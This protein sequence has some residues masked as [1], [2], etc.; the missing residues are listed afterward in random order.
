MRCGLGRVSAM[1]LY[2][3]FL[4]APCARFHARSP[5]SVL[6]DWS[7]L[8]MLWNRLECLDELPCSARDLSCIIGKVF[9]RRTS[10]S[11]VLLASGLRAVQFRFLQCAPKLFRHQCLPVLACESI[12]ACRLCACGVRGDLQHCHCLPGLYMEASICWTCPYGS[13]TL[14]PGAVAA[15]S[16]SCM[17]GFVNMS[18][19]PSLCGPC[20][21]GYFCNGGTHRERCAESQTTLLDVASDRTQCLCVSGTF[22]FGEACA[23]CPP[24]HYKR[25]IGNMPC[26]PCPAGTWSNATGA[27]SDA[28]CQACPSGST[29][30]AA[31]SELE[32][33]CVRPHDDQQVTCTSGTSCATRIPIRS[34]KFLILAFGQ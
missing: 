18:N 24:G 14:E 25:S 32:D 23:N 33:F 20:G 10:Y 8:V 1:R 28:T 6:P 31:G 9:L 11:N 29:T 4:V 17:P 16:C 5:Q 12:I 30:A 27:D 21:T 15:T 22:L 7:L 19:N 3:V 34:L 13:T 2:G 26:E